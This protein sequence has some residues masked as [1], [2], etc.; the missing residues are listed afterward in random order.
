MGGINAVSTL[1]ALVL[2]GMYILTRPGRRRRALAGWWVPAVLLATAWWAGPLLYQG[3]YGFNFLPY[4]EQ[5][6][7]T[8]QT[9]SA[10]TVLHGSG[11]WVAY[12]NFGQPWLT[13]GSVLT[14]TGWAI[15]AGT[16]TAAAGLAGLARRDLPEALWLRCTAGVAAVYALAG[17]GGPLGGPLHQSVQALLDG[18]L[19]ALR[20]VYKIE[21]VLAAVVALGIAHVLARAAWPRAAWL[22]AVGRPAGAVAAA[23]I[24]AGLGLP[25]LTGQALQPG[26]FTQVPAY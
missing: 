13:A 2:P 24:L 14:R 3:R 11:N 9:M 6:T 25:Y 8:T 20:N 7:T 16:V 12:L 23:G 17:Y 22:R 26:S 15:A 19:S 5:A 10:A 1:A 21:P 18:A 4:V